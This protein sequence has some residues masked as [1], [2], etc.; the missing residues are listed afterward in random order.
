M[1]LGNGYGYGQTARIRQG[2]P[3]FATISFDCLLGDRQSQP[4]A[5]SLCFAAGKGLKNLFKL[6]SIYPVPLIGDRDM[7]PA[8]PD[9]SPDANNGMIGRIFDCIANDIFQRTINQLAVDF[10]HEGIGSVD[11]DG[12]M[13]C[14]SLE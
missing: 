3:D 7:E 10:G 12:N 1:F 6:R 13:T 9:I 14:L 2:G 5:A 8:L 11:F 4:I